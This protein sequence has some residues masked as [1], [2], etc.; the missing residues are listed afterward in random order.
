MNHDISLGEI[1]AKFADLIWEN[2]PVSSGE[3]VK[4]AEESL[5]WKKSTTY[6][7]LK[8]L[9]DRGLFRNENGAVTSLISR[10]EFYGRR[11]EQFVRE[12]FGGSL[13]RFLTAFSGRRKLTEE[14]VDALMKFIDENRG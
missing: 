9:G 5:G 7:V 2:E 8:R 11:S 3:L 13:P 1:E 10:E 14:E 12:T 6:T 4:L